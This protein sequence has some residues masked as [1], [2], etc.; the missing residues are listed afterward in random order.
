M[1]L[2]TWDR[3][4]AIGYVEKM[5][6]EIVRLR[7]E[8]AALRTP[9]G[10]IQKT[11]P[12]LCSNW[13]SGL[14]ETESG[15]SRI[16]R[17]YQQDLETAKRNDAINQSNQTLVANLKKVVEATGFPSTHHEWKRNKYINVPSEWVQCFWVPVEN[18]TSEVEERFKK[19]KQHRESHLAD[20]EKKRLQRE[21]EQAEIESK[22]VRDLAFVDLC[23]E[24]G[25][26]PLDATTDAL[27]ESILSRCK[28]LR[29]AVAG[30]ETRNDWSDGCWR[31]EQELRS[32]EITCPI[33][34][35]IDS[36]WR[37]ICENFEDGRQF[38]D[39]EWDYDKVM[40]LANEH[41]VALW[42]RFESTQ[43]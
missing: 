27:R 36:E 23:R 15:W 32:F 40:G 10:A 17:E 42:N 30:M 41:A 18:G 28:Y 34:A 5:Q 31:V 33:D 29:L 6:A 43:S 4:Q 11:E 3:D 35:E 37:G 9:F 8:N 24:C 7:S 39:C 2:E 12:L 21:R 26:N 19:Y 14:V 20:Q 16:E 25:L 13:N 1:A 22:K 38:R